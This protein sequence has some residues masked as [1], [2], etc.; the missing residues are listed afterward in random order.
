MRAREERT[1]RRAT[2]WGL[3]ISLQLFGASRGWGADAHSE[4][5][6]VARRLF[7]RA[8]ELMTEQRYDEACG[9]FEESQRLDPGG[10]TLLNLA[11]CYEL[12][13]R[14]AS[15][16]VTFHQA[17]LLAERHGRSDRKVFAEQRIA[18]LGH[19]LSYLQLVV[20][21][22]A[23]VPGIRIRLNGF[24]LGEPAWGESL[25]VD[26][27][28]RIVEITAPGRRAVR[29]NVV[30]RDNADIQAIRVPPLE[31]GIGAPVATRTLGSSDR[32]N[33][34]LTSGI[35]VGGVGI[36][37]LVTGTFFGLRAILRKN[38]ADELCATPERCEPT[39]F[40]VNA[41]ARRDGNL[42]TALIAGG[43][44]LLGVGVVLVLTPPVDARG[45]AL[46][47]SIPLKF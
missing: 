11:L 10:G 29:I 36:A 25:P 13:G 41:D 17:A 38:R 40:S 8:R 35:V 22:E 12:S 46:E 24:E 39:S 5:K 33:A 43:A 1:L 20:P 31:A 14:T 26:P 3:V 28:E 19:R 21:N 44:G 42:S 4:T 16:W 2:G 34:Y 45:V 27:G 30:V 18:A 9:K 37:S 7:D 32:G 47:L 23:K 6:A 15:A